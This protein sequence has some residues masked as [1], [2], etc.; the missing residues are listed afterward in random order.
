VR[1]AYFDQYRPAE[2]PCSARSQDEFTARI[3]KELAGS[4]PVK[5]AL[6]AA[7]VMRTLNRH[8]TE[9]Q[10]RKV[11]D[12]LPRSIRALWPEPGET[13]KN[14][15]AAP[16]AKEPPAAKESAPGAP[17]PSQGTAVGGSRDTV[18]RELGRTGAAGEASSIAQ[19][20]PGL[21]DDS[22]R[23]VDVDP[24]TA[25]AVEQAVGKREGPNRGRA[26]MRPRRGGE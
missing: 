16:A 17:G 23:P 18:E 26:K 11:R 24:A 21:P 5:P 15:T 25:Q 7:V 1:G 6:A 2:Q 9:G 14:A 4:R 20:A 19:S 13:A 10:I 8:L 22:S 3:Q 12:T